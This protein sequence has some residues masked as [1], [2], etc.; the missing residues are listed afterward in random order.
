MRK[1]GGKASDDSPSSLSLSLPTSFDD[2]LD[3]SPF[4]VGGGVTLEPSTR[5]PA[6]V[7]PVTNLSHQMMAARILELESQVEHLTHGRRMLETHM[8]HER[9][10]AAAELQEQGDKWRREVDAMRRT[11]VCE[12]GLRDMGYGRDR[13][14]GGSRA[15]L[16]IILAMYG[17]G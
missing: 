14:Q 13:S 4:I 3:I 6:S 11:Q 7:G 12:F 8:R 16:V 10:Q 5:R 17:N 1:R 2:S 9:E 15:Y